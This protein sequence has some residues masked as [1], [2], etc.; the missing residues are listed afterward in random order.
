MV[1]AVRK[2]K[3]AEWIQQNLVRYSQKSWGLGGRGQK[4]SGTKTGMGLE[5]GQE[6]SE[7]S[8]GSLKLNC[9]I[10]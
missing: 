6:H 8:S 2:G 4:M 5:R 10:I 3:V 9:H 7:K 1:T